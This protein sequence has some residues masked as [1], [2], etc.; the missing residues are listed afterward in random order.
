MA[1]ARKLLAPGAFIGGLI[2]AYLIAQATGAIT[3]VGYESQSRKQMG[4]VGLGFGGFGLRHPVWLGAGEVIA[5][6]YEIDARFGAVALTVRPPL[7]L[8]ANALQAA[9]AYV[10]GK[11]SGRVLFQAGAPGWY[12]FQTRPSPLGGPRC[13]KPNASLQ[14]LFAGDADCPT[15]DVSYRV[16][17]RR[18]GR[19]RDDGAA[20]LTVPPPG[21]TLVT[22][23]VRD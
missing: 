4:F 21:G 23:R 18:A 6:D 8:R 3:V 9:T 1:I 16:T 10:E 17:W 7:L 2:L 20:R 12:V 15:Y 11:R 22:A 14:D 13:H 5:A 19:T